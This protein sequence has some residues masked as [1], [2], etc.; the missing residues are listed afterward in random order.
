MRKGVEETGRERLH[1][2]LAVGG[3]TFRDK[4]KSLAGGG[5][6][7]TRGK[8]E[9]RQ[10]AS[11]ADVVRAVEQ[12]KG[13][14]HEEFVNRR[15]GWGMPLVMWLARRCCGMKLREIGDALG[16]KDDAAVSDRLRRFER[17]SAANR[18]LEIVCKDAML[19]LN[20]EI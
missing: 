15:G 14:K 20:L 5:V 2:A 12:V 1:D 3:E 6:R 10:R 19:I 7:E 13:G 4:I 16:G 18:K 17:E 9:L 8:R 11:F